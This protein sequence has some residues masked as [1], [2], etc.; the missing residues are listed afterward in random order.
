ME[1]CASCSH[2]FSPFMSA[3]STPTHR[4]V[5]TSSYYYYARQNCTMLAASGLVSGGAVGAAFGAAFELSNRA[6]SGLPARYIAQGIAQAALRNGI[7]FGAWSGTF[8][9]TKC[10]FARLRGTD[11]IVGAAAAGA[12]TGALLTVAATGGN[13]QLARP[14]IP[15]NAAASALVAAVFSAMS[16]V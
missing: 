4:V 12:T 10:V 8:R 3:L 16:R 14:S 9:G 13:F 6:G 1:K 15:G 11:D 5:P 2:S 7:A